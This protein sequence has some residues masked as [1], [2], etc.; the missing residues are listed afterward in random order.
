MSTTVTLSKDLGGKKAGATITVS[1]EDVAQRLVE[2]GLAE[3]VK[4]TPKAKAKPKPEKSDS[5]KL[6]DPA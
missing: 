3:H 6:S 1:G 4:A 2:R 5:E